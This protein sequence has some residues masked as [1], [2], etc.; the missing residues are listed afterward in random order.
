MRFEKLDIAQTNFYNF[1]R[2]FFNQ[3]Q[4]YPEQEYLKEN[5]LKYS[6]MWEAQED[7]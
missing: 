6:F 1:Y 3:E 4:Y 7:L 5:G 2:P